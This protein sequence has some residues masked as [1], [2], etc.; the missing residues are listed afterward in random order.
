MPVK[1]APPKA[2][3]PLHPPDDSMWQT[4]SAHYE[5]PLAGA[6]SVFLH[7]LVIGMLAVGGIAFFFTFNRDA[8]KPPS[9]DMVMIEGGGTGFEGLG[10]EPGL[11][12][13]PAAGG[14]TELIAPLPDQATEPRTQSLLPKETPPELDIP[15]IDDGTPPVDN[16]LAIELAK[17]AKQADDEVRA[18]MDLPKAP[19]AKPR[20]KQ[21]GST[22]PGNLKGQVGQSGAGGA[23]GVGS[24]QGPGT[25]TGGPGGRPAAT[26]QEIF[27]WRWR[28]DL[29]GDG[30]EHA[31]KL[32]AMGVTLAIPDGRGGFFLITDLNRRPVE[33]RKDSL[34]AFKDA[35]KW[36]NQKPDSLQGLARELQ[37]K[38]VP[39]YAVLLLPKEREEK[40]AAEEAQYARDKGRDLARIQATVFDFRLVNGMYDPVVTKQ[41]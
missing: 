9:M 5:L 7:G 18:A 39:Q 28:F 34:V 38:F 26:K 19:P 6:T 14:R 33:L 25:G 41:E 16:E 13:A 3:D 8:A 4:Y 22:G 36:Y 21:A 10:G 15:L 24:K 23:G 1:T 27:A 30:K 20:P 37:L 31:R 12:G 17:I 40:M 35:V 29:S 32:A 11:P 2:T